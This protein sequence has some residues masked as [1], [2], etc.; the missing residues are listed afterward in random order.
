MFDKANFWKNIYK[1]M[2]VLQNIYYLYIIF[3]KLI[4]KISKFNHFLMAV[5]TLL[6]KVIIL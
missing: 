4:L 1:Y 6:V 5:A 3:R 2:R